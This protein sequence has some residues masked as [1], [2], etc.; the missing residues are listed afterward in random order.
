MGIKIHDESYSQWVSES[1]LFECVSLLPDTKL[2][3]ARCLRTTTRNCYHNIPPLIFSAQ[4][5]SLDPFIFLVEQISSYLSVSTVTAL[6]TWPHLCPVPWVT[7]L[8]HQ[9]TTDTWRSE[10][11]GFYKPSCFVV[12]FFS[13]ISLVPRK[14][15]SLSLLPTPNPKPL[16][17]AGI[18]SY[19]NINISLE[20]ITFGVIVPY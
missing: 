2:E 8:Q 14:I 18:I 17:C 5:N 19:N 12:G 3:T 9:V 11:R 7:D 1:L 15:P 4:S 16:C 13:L 6:P 10:E 20:L